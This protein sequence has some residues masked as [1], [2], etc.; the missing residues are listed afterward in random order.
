MTIFTIKQNHTNNTKVESPVEQHRTKR[1]IH[2]V[3]EKVSLSGFPA[4]RK[5]SRKFSQSSRIPGK[6]RLRVYG[7]YSSLFRVGCSA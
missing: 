5:T 7:R 2:F 4:S 6:M 3:A 1:E